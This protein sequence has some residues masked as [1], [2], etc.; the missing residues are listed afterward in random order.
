[1]LRS[2]LR[3]RT[4][5]EVG[6]DDERIRNNLR[7]RAF[8]D[9]SAFGQHENVFR[10]THHRLHD[11]L[12]HQDRDTAPAKI[13]NDGNDIPDLGW[14]EARQH[15]IQKQYLGLRSKRARKL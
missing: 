15:L 11:M 13:A 7:R 12:N 14:I 1:M 2:Q 6:L 8:G 3:C 4:T 9:D 10:E 5:A